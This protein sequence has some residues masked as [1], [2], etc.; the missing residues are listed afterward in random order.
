MVILVIMALDWA[1]NKFSARFPQGKRTEANSTNIN[2]NN[3]IFPSYYIL[4]FYHI[5]FY[6]FIDMQNFKINIEHCIVNKAQWKHC[7]MEF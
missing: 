1:I 3:F 4:I 5:N 6:V 7:S 2:K